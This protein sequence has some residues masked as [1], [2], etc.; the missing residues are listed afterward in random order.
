MFALL[1]CKGGLH[2][3]QG[4]DFPC[5]FSQPERVR[6][7][8]CAPGDVC[9]VDNLCRRYRYE[10]PQFDNGASAPRFELA[11]LKHPLQLSQPIELVTHSVSS[12]GNRLL[13]VT[14][15]GP[16]TEVFG[17]R[18]NQGIELTRQRSPLGSE[19]LTAIAM[20]NTDPFI[21]A[22]GRFSG[23]NA[24]FFFPSTELD[25]GGPVGMMRFRE[26]DR[27][28]TGRSRVAVVRLEPDGGEVGE[29]AI[30][31]VPGSNNP[32]ASFDFDEPLADGGSEPRRVV[33]VRYLPASGMFGDDDRLLLTRQGLFLERRV[34]RAV[35]LSGVDE[36][37]PSHLV[38][39]P[40]P[41]TD[42]RH[43]GSGT[44]AAFVSSG[45]GTPV[46]LST[47]RLDRGQTP[48]A[49]RTWNDC[50]PCATR[51]AAFAPAL[52]LGTPVVEVLCSTP[53]GPA[54]SR[55][56]YSLVR[57]TGSAAVDERQPCALQPVE[58]PF[59][60]AQL[61]EG[62]R[63]RR[64]AEGSQLATVTFDDSF[65]AGV[66]LGGRRGQLWSGPTFSRA[67][68]LFLERVPTSFGTFPSPAG[69]PLQAVLTDR[70]A[71]VLRD[72]AIGY[73]VLDLQ[74]A[75]A[76]L[77]EDSVGAALIGQALG[78]GVLSSGDLIFIDPLSDAGTKLTFGP[79]LLD[80]RGAA[81][82]G[83]FFGEAVTA[84]DGGLVSFVLTADDSI[85]FTPAPAAG[86]TTGQSNTLPPLTPQLTPASSSPIRS[87][88]LERSAVGTD[89][90]TRVRGY[91]V[92]GRS[93]FVITLSGTPPRWTATPILLQ[94][95]EPIETWMDHPL[96][97]LGRIGYRDGQVFTLPGGFLLVNELPRDAGANPPQVL[98]YEN[99]GGWP[100]AMTSNGLFEAHYAVDGGYLQNRFEDGGI[101]RAM[102]WALVTLPDG[103]QPWLGRPS[104]LH[105]TQTVEPYDPA[106]GI[107]RDPI[108]ATAK[109][110]HL[111][112]YTDDQVVEVGTLVR[113]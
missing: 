16:Q 82:Q 13:A 113:R 40:A 110:F 51:I 112:V 95:G 43:D 14:G 41:R 65:G 69:G 60:L 59:P 11:K 56:A 54:G 47:W 58:A 103:G 102:S 32:D 30:E 78:W 5:D 12:D 3:E 10:G 55:N 68:P 99:L 86:T 25:A 62:V 73:E 61:H 31:F 88:A 91:V 38:Q 57:V 105:V 100:V 18:A 108:P 94:G 93:L 9:G 74:N 89:G 28:R 24:T 33:D 20:A 101:N 66:L 26:G 63:G 29:G 72:P 27:L 104:R 4:N 15:R 79:R 42:L 106:S 7:A 44:L 85:Y 45:N 96:G 67:L 37:M 107:L 2:T 6:D 70:Y 97:G 49:A 23:A 39:P 17:L 46:V 22:L 76:L 21:V 36:A 90:V 77:P 80:A 111:L 81:A 50:Q 52:E 64:L 19:D 1:A 8:V 53:M 83:P 35:R 98:D 71:A 48:S 87:F 34:S 92:A 84:T 75:G 109:V